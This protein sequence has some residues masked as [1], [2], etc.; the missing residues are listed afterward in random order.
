MLNFTEFVGPFAQPVQIPLN[1]STTLWWISHSL[2]WVVGH[3][4][5]GALCL[6]IWLVNEDVEQYWC[7]YWPL[8]YITGDQ[9][10]AGHRAADDNPWN[11]AV[12]FLV[13]RCLPSI[14]TLSMRVFRSTVLRHSKKTKQQQKK[15]IHSRRQSGWSSMIC[16]IH[17][18]EYFCVASQPFTEKIYIRSKLLVT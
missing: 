15:H 13:S 14:L 2:C 1:G 4:V 10:P 11:L 8:G 9:T 7:R 6:I 12:Q 16:G 3:F 5:E 18:R 17:G